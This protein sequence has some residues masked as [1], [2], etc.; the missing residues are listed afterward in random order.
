M[1]ADRSL[2]ILCQPELYDITAG[3]H[4]K[5]ILASY[6]TYVLGHLRN[7]TINRNWVEIM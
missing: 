1:A 2:S 6:K 3:V 4:L 7:E 5:E